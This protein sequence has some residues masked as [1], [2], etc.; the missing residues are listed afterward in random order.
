MGR[1]LVVRAGAYGD[2]IC[3]TNV[4]RALD[5]QGWDVGLCYNQKGA[6]V[7]TRNPRIKERVFWEPA[8]TKFIAELQ[9]DHEAFEKRVAEMGAGYD[10]VV[11]LQNTLENSLVE[12]QI[13]EGFYWP[14]YMRREKNA[15]INYY[16]QGMHAAGLS[17]DGRSGELWF[18]NEEH[19]IV[20]KSL[21]KVQDRFIVLWCWRGTMYQKAIYELAEETITRFCAE[22]PNALVMTIGDKG[23]KQFEFDHPQVVHKSGV[24]PFR[25]AALLTKYVDMVVTPETGLGVA[26]GAYGTP[27]VMLLTSSS[28]QNIVA[29]DENDFSIQSEAWCSPCFRAIYNTD[30]CEHLEGK[31]AP[32]GMPLPICVAFDR[33]RL[34]DRITEARDHA[35]RI[36]RKQHD[37]SEERPVYV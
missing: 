1:V 18:S 28:L 19:A 15:H 26:A 27:K 6:Q 37:P 16:D 17:P 3:I 32:D 14:L 13:R 25:Q 30:C 31:N 2:H 12:N 11:N 29:N 7:H 36:G 4:I 35:M 24:Y 10:K 20:A 21:E 34:F 5:E 33:E 23:C 8:N 9:Q 22:N